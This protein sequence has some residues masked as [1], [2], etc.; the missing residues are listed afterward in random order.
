MNEIS[1]VQWF[2]IQTKTKFC[3][4]SPRAK[5]SGRRLSAKL[6]PI[7]VDKRCHVISMA[8]PYGRILGFLDRV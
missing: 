6:M 4:L 8:D 3:G 1:E 5:S 7:F 2:E